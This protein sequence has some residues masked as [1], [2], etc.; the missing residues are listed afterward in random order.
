[1]STGLGSGIGVPLLLSMWFILHKEFQKKNEKMRKERYF[2]QNGGPLLQQKTNEGTIRKTKHFCAKELEKATDHFN[3]NRILG[4]GG[5]GTVYKGMLCDGKIVAVKKSMQVDEQQ[6]EQFINEIVILSQVDHKNVVK[7]LGC[8]LETEVPLLV[9]EFV[10]NGT[11]FNLIHD[12]NT[13]FQFS[14]DMRLQIATDIAGALAYLHSSCSLQICHRDIKSSNI[15]LD[16]KYV[17]K[18][19]DFGISRSVAQDRTHFTTNVKGTFGYFDPEYFQSHHYNEKSDVYSF[20]VVLAEILTGN[21][22]IFYERSEEMQ[23][24]LAWHFLESIEENKLD[25]ILD[26]KVSMEGRREEV[27]AVARIAQ[28]CLNL[29]RGV[30]PT[31]K[32]VA[33]QLESLRISRQPSTFELKLE[34][35]N[36]VVISNIQSAFTTSCTSEASTTFSDIQPL[37]FEVAE[38]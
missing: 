21:M 37:M 22:P 4:Q 6:L 27:T 31:M 30:R 5:Q 26:P 8:C 15:L 33:T 29:K 35:A 38:V 34:E 2:K 16:E 28:N 25:S 24:S 19:A 36:S 3:E 13:Q 18:V 7:L 17:V 1:M 32:E 10:P 20:G 9:Y 12:S 23:K 14:W 11:L